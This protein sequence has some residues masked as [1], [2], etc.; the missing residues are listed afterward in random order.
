MAKKIIILML[1]LPLL[2]MV[3]LFTTTN[4]I[5]LEVDMKV[6]NVEF[7]ENE[8]I[9]LEYN[10]K[11]YQL[12]YTVYPTNATNQKVSFEADNEVVEVSPEG[13]ILP[14]SVGKSK[15][16]VTTNDGAFKDSVYVEI[17]S[18]TLKE[19]DVF[20]SK[21]VL[22][23]G[24][25]IKFTPE[26]NPSDVSDDRVKVTSSDESVISVNNNYIFAKK[27][28]K[29]KLTFTPYISEG[30]SVTYDFEV[31]N[32]DLLDINETSIKTYDKKGELALSIDT[33][34]NYQVEYGVYNFKDELVDSVKLTYDKENNVIR[35]EYLENNYSTLY[36]KITL[37]LDNG[38]IIEKR[39][40]LKLVNLSE[41][42]V[43]FTN[44]LK[45]VTVNNSSYL[46]YETNPSNIPFKYHVEVDNDNL[47][48]VMIDDGFVIFEAKKAGLTNIR[49]FATLGDTTISDVCEVV[50]KPRNIIIT[51]QTKHYGIENILT[52]GKNYLNNSNILKFH[53]TTSSN[54]SNNFS[55]FI[56]F[57]TNNDNISIDKNGNISFRNNDIFNEVVDVYVKF[58]YKNV[59]LK[60]ELFKVR[61]ISNAYNAFNYN[62]LNQLIY[63]NQK[64]VLHNDIK[65]DFG[66]NTNK[67][68]TEM[69]TTYDYQY[70]L[71]TERDIP[72]IKVLLPVKN[73]IYGNGYMI[74]ANKVTNR[75]DA[76]GKPLE[77]AIFKGPLDF[78]RAQARGGANLSAASV[79]AQDNIV[80]ALFDNVTINNLNLESMSDITDLT[81]LNYAGT[82]VEVFGDNV[83]ILN[84][85]IS[86][87]RTLIRIFGSDNNP[88][89]KLHVNIQN[90]IMRNAREFLLRTGS[91]KLEF[92]QNNPTPL[93]PGDNL[94]NTFPRQNAYYKLS[95]TDK[96]KYDDKFIMNF[97]TLDNVSFEKSGIFS[98]GLDS[99]FSGG[100]LHQGSDFNYGD[101][102]YGWHKLAKTSYGTKLILKNEVR[103]YDWKNLDKVDSSTL[104]EV[105]LSENIPNNPFEK[106]KFDVASM[107]KILSQKEGFN[108]VLCKYNNADYVHG[109]I[110]YFGGG[111]N[112]NVVDFA[113]S[114]IGLADFKDYIIA[115]KDV[116]Q[117]I[118]K[119]AA[120]DHPFLFKLFDSTSTN[121]TPA[122]QNE[123]FSSGKQ[124]DFI[125]K[126]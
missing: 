72:K 73:D 5:S 106:L 4:R 68:F 82:T 125:L 23:V 91:N 33:T 28:G 103:I 62:E 89:K 61:F 79:K 22:V 107:V 58:S 83:N 120:G 96:K 3:V 35:Y 123:I 71:N 45:E 18:N 51:E 113:E 46:Y 9:E 109:G 84:S 39:C 87:G 65:N 27:K 6:E 121:F 24:E 37:I 8:I 30:L 100:L 54:V 119:I 36:I 40:D 97:V 63:N 43:S 104:I 93:L 20:F 80:L 85:R 108:N 76:T 44:K 59:V 53:Y 1:F 99:H 48:N 60:S 94:G 126:R 90:T 14:K 49:L 57:E 13:K 88:D 55:D 38:A 70:Y 52:I 12:S 101:L 105:E 75:V 81:E 69:N 118:L 110:A 47:I 122:I 98:I 41:A 116:G 56:S 34:D 17:Y 66:D 78:V 42:S 32:E 25:K 19:F 31:I 29:A 124:Y 95:N 15:V 26:F 114:Y 77:D 86:N 92:D 50:I 115:L 7:N 67:L 16:T 10:E 117:D 11:D 111:K 21:D 74:S 112:Y 64:V 2:V 102:V